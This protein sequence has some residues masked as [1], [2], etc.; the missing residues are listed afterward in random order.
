MLTENAVAQGAVM[1]VCTLI[2]GL[3][4]RLIEMLGARDKL[5]YDKRL[6]ELE[7]SVVECKQKHNDCEEAHGRSLT[8]IEAL[9]VEMKE[10]D[11]RDKAELRAMLEAVRHDSQQRTQPATPTRNPRGP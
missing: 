10:R 3:G 6:T 1:V 2:G 11:A 5:K 8:E 4:G 9:R 7:T